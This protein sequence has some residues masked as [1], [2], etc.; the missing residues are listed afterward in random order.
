MKAI[1]YLP[2]HRKYIKRWDYYQVD[3][4]ALNDLFDEVELCNSLWDVIKTRQN[5]SAIY[6]WWW[7]S[8][9]PVILLS[10]LLRIP[11]VVTGAIHMYDMSG[12]PDFYTKSASYRFFTTISLRLA[13]AN[14]F[15]S[16]DQFHQV[17]S[18][19]CVNNPI[20]VRSSLKK[21]HSS[22]EFD[23]VR[24]ST[25]SQPID[26]KIVFLSIV[27]QTSDQLK[28]KGLWETLEAMLIL[29]RDGFDN[30]RWLIAG[31]RGDA[32]A[33]I[34]Q[35]IQLL[36][37]SD[38]VTV[39]T[40]ISTDQKNELYAKADLFVQPS[41]CEGFGNASLEAMSYGL[42]ALV[43]RYTAQP[44]SV[45]HI[46]LI[47][48]D[49]TPKHIAEKLRYFIELSDVERLKLSKSAFQRAH[50]EFSYLH[51]LR[52]LD[53]VFSSVSCDYISRFED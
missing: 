18:H 26:K 39:I 38:Q 23:L 19:L 30:F 51:R 11:C 9:F 49:I 4:S 24:G 44:E 15:I 21:Q 14:L 6:C 20:I 40:D 13:S 25:S 31:A 32:T 34:Y 48:H 53:A 8:S 7:H 37:L 43:S 47:V 36:G 2:V 46:G 10:R 27:W 28:R 41:W 50:S 3:I 33:T 16:A 12:S 5:A 1:L 42:P 29:K 52:E 35:Q 17:T 45:G 22:I